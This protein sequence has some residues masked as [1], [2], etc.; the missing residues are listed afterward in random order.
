MGQEDLRQIHQNKQD[1]SQESAENG[2]ERLKPDFRYDQILKTEGASSQLKDEFKRIFVALNF[3]ESAAKTVADIFFSVKPQ[4]HLTHF[5]LLVSNFLVWGSYLPLSAL[6]K[7]EINIMNP[8]H[9]QKLSI[10]RLSYS[11]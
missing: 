9:T 7:R 3:I 6:N 4:F 10:V 2:L 5:K 8:E 11:L 1:R